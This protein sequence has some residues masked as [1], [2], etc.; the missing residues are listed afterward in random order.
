MLPPGQSSAA[1]ASDGQPCAEKTQGDDPELWDALSVSARLLANRSSEL[2]DLCKALSTGTPTASTFQ[3]SEGEAEASYSSTP[4]GT[5]LSL[6]RD[7]AEAGGSAAAGTAAGTAAC[8]AVAGQPRHPAS[9]DGID[10]SRCWPPAP[11]PDAWRAEGYTSCADAV[12]ASGMVEEPALQLVAQAPSP[13]PVVEVDHEEVTAASGTPEAPVDE[14]SVQDVCQWVS[15]ALQL[16]SNVVDV[17]RSEEVTGIVL[18]TLTE[19]DLVSIGISRLGWRRRLTLGIF[20]LLQARQQQAELAGAP[21]RRARSA[22]DFHA[23]RLHALPAPWPH[24]AD[25]VP[26]TEQA[27]E[28]SSP[29][30]SKCGGEIWCRPLAPA[31][32]MRAAEASS[33]CAGGCQGCESCV[34]TPPCARGAWHWTPPMKIT[35]STPTSSQGMRTAAVALAAAAAAAAAT[36]AS[37]QCTSP[38]TARSLAPASPWVAATASPRCGFNRSSPSTTP[39]NLEHIAR[40]RS[41]SAERYAYRRVDRTLGDF[42]PSTLLQNWQIANEVPLGAPRASFRGRRGGRKPQFVPLRMPRG[43]YQ[44]EAMRVYAVDRRCNSIPDLHMTGTLPIS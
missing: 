3:S 43:S 7:R 34:Q 33:D 38:A 4:S 2:R 25:T 23:R 24:S 27:F 14:W 30:S 26:A 11:L 41:A 39:W 18:C 31:A 15:N 32:A 22:T 6:D 10:R 20:E 19:A 40:H 28:H 16:P 1:P 29:R 44:R 5:V 37:R 17:L 36:A 21:L 12:G 9:Q 8:A 42:E 13:M 35:A